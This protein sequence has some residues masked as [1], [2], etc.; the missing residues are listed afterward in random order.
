MELRSSNQTNDNR[1]NIEEIEKEKEGDMNADDDAV[2]LCYNLRSGR[3][4]DYTYIYNHVVDDEII[5][6]NDE[7]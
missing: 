1:G 5:D 3:K 2:V 7:I 6:K 4:L